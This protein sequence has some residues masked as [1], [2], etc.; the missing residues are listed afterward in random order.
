VGY[1]PR[2]LP[3]WARKPGTATRV[4]GRIEA[5][6]DWARVN[7]F[8]TEKTGGLARPSRSSAASTHEGPHHAALPYREGG[9]FTGELWND[10]ATGS[11]ALQFLILTATRTRLALRGL[12]R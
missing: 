1:C 11:L 10:G 9:D 6:V 3:L 2:I 7:E 4:R 8:R 12:N 5:I